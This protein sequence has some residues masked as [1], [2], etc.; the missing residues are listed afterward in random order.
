MSTAT[1]I[2][3]NK[4]GPPLNALMKMRRN[5]TALGVLP[6]KVL[7][8][9]L[10]YPTALWKSVDPAVRDTVL[11][12]YCH[13]LNKVWWLTLAFGESRLPIVMTTAGALLFVTLAM[14]D[15]NLRKLSEEAT[16]MR[17]AI[18]LPLT[19]AVERG[20]SLA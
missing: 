5:V 8:Q 12:V 4:V 13:A 2:F 16:R 10:A 7:A 17:N 18:C 15:L 6:P 19:P 9:V 3:E 1:N 20:K 11:D 14:R